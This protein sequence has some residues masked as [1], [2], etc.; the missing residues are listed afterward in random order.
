MGQKDLENKE[1]FMRSKKGFLDSKTVGTKTQEKEHGCHVRDSIKSWRMEHIL[2]LEALMGDEG[3]EVL[4][5][6][7]RYYLT[8]NRKSLGALEN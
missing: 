1:N 3:F 4:S 6:K 8:C 7:F 2:Q 5:M